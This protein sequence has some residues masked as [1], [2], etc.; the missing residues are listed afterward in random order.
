MNQVEEAFDRFIRGK[1]LKL[2]SQRKKI[3]KAVFHTHRHFTA[4]ELYDMLHHERL[5]ISRATIY[6]TLS[7]LEEGKFL[8]SLDVG[9]DSKYY[10]HIM[11]HAHH[12]H[13]ICVNC[14]K[15]IEFRDDNIEALQDQVSRSHGFLVTSHSL[16]IFGL[17]KSCRPRSR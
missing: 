5:R 13:M 14:G 1:G 15:F 16:K 3:L 8:E 17:C 2:T 4:D 11:G 10:E 7:L 6:R 12:D 9:K